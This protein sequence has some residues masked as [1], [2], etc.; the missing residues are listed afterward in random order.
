[1][2]TDVRLEVLAT[3][4]DTPPPRSVEFWAEILARNS[5][6]YAPLALSG[7]LAVSPARAITM[8]PSLPNT[9]RMGQLAALKL[10]LAWDTLPSAQRF[11]FVRDI[12]AILQKCGPV[13][14]APV[15][16]W[17]ET[18]RS[19]RVPD[20]NTSLSNALFAFFG[21]AINAQAFTPKLCPA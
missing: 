7:V 10:D 5:I 20:F 2:A 1:M 8:L 15:M 12:K 19:T 11:Q 13:F 16:E 6:E 18:K 17:A 4:V 3:L 14:A 21:K 9:E